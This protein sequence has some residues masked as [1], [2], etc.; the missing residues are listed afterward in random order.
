MKCAYCER[1]EAD[2]ALKAPKPICPKCWLGQLR[3]IRV[4]PKGRRA[5]ELHREGKSE[6]E[7]K[8]QL[9]KEGFR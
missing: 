6:A 8:V 4:T 1:Y 5:A 3:N 7:I 9:E 2:P